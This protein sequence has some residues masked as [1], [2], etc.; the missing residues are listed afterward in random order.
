MSRIAV[1]ALAVF[2][3]GCESTTELGETD[4]TAAD[5][6]AAY[7]ATTL[8]TTTA[9]EVTDELAA[10]A[11]LRITLEEDGAT[12]GRL[13]VPGGDEDGSDFDAD[14]A[15]TWGIDGETVT[16]DHPADTFVRNMPFEYQNGRLVGERTFGETR[17]RVELTPTG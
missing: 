8:T 2:V 15:G 12:S 10:G 11:Q 14:L 4:L 1:L 6:A 5:V 7:E 13:F 17:V 3:I 9:G 16:F